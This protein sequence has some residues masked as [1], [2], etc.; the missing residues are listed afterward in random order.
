MQ[1]SAFTSLGAD[2]QYSETAQIDIYVGIVQ[3]LPN[4]RIFF[5]VGNFELDRVETS[6]SIDDLHND[7][8][9]KTDTQWRQVR[10]IT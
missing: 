7:T 8:W 3:S 6:L 10:A 5:P 2:H 9:G 1:P 4:T